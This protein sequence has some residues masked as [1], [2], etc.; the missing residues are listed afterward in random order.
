MLNI[1]NKSVEP[2]KKVKTVIYYFQ[3]TNSFDIPKSHCLRN[4]QIHVRELVFKLD[5]IHFII[6]ILLDS[7]LHE[8]KVQQWYKLKL[9]ADFWCLFLVMLFF[10]NA[11]IFQF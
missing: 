8:C 10:L 5:E 3:S 6:K 7:T 9:V 4:V 11:F 2:I 1:D